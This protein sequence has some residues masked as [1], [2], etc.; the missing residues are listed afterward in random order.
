MLTWHTYE[1][2]RDSYAF[3]TEWNVQAVRVFADHYTVGIKFARYDA[4]N[5]VLNL[6]RNG[7]AS[8]GKQA[9]DSD[10]FWVWG[11]VRF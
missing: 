2:D 11:E 10:K 4:D 1:S 3:G 9:F 5:N 8:A 6:G 7:P